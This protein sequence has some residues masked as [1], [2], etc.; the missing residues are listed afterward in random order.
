MVYMHTIHVRNVR[1]F[2]GGIGEQESGSRRGRGGGVAEKGERIGKGKNYHEDCIRAM[3]KNEVTGGGGKGENKRK[4]RKQE[5][6]E[7]TGRVKENR[8]NGNKQKEWYTG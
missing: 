2:C 6:R 4:G 8:R 7:K 3:D 1:G 5:E